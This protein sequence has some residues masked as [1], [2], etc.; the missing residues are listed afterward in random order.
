MEVV[1]LRVSYG[2]SQMKTNFG[3]LLVIVSIILVDGI[4]RLRS[5]SIQNRSN[6]SRIIK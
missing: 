4:L 3:V 5:S 6:I 1:R 2:S